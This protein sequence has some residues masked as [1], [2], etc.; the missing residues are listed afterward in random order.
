M[1]KAKKPKKKKAES[2]EEIDE[3]LLDKDFRE[4]LIDIGKM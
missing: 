3:I 2:E 4:L 1:K